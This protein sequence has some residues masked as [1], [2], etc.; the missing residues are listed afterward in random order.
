VRAKAG[1]S[2]I[3]KRPVAG[4]VHVATPAAGFSGVS[5]DT[6]CAKAHHGGPGQAVY[7]F[8][9]ED[10]DWWEDRLGRVLPNGIFGENITT[11]GLDMT[12]SRLGERWQIGEELVLAVTAPRVPCANFAVWMNER[13]WLKDFRDRAR[14][15]AYLRVI[16]PGTAQE[17]D[18]IEVVHR[19]DHDVDVGLCFR[20]LTGN[21]GLLP[22]LLA[23][24]DDL[25]P[26]MRERALAG[27][28][29]DIDDDPVLGEA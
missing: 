3:D 10:L 16:V 20:A 28:P 23:A 1:V 21:R 14:P 5:G 17:G 25:E 27:R 8:A 29:I 19:P 12:R 2:G 26:E 22:E 6:V 7:A 18:A 11:I 4:P 9:R 13:G 24:G 15:G